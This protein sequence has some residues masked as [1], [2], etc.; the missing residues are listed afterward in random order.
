VVEARKRFGDWEGD[1]LYGKHTRIC[2]LTLD[3]RLRAQ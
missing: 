1:T 3:C 2:L